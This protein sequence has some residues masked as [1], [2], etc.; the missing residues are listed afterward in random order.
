MKKIKLQRTRSAIAIT[1]KALRKVLPLI[2]PGTREKDISKALKGWIKYF[3]AEKFS[4]SPIVAS[5]RRSAI[6]HG[7]ATGRTLKKGDIVVVDF[8]VVYK[9]YCT[10]ITRSFVVGP[11]NSRQ[12]RIH[13]T[14]LGARKKAL[15]VIRHGTPSCEIDK[16]ARDHIKKNN[17][18]GSFIHTTGHGIGRKVHEAPKISL[19]NKNMI[20]SGMIL[21]VEPGIYFKGW[22]GM[23]IEDMVLVTARGCKV[24]TSA[25]RG[26][27]PI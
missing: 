7:F 2:R 3:G 10:D 5:G 18:G 27:K 23:R 20:K 1:E 6:P 22:G 24:L 11:P 13:K 26:L 9:G 21:T 8:G 19:G 4:F 12:M 17:F 16:A 25:K 14:L 15:R